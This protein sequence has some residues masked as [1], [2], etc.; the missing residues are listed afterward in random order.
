MT[1]GSYRKI[2]SD[3]WSHLHMLVKD[4]ANYSSNWDNKLRD[5]LEYPSSEWWARA[6]FAVRLDLI[7]WGAEIWL[8]FIDALWVPLWE[9]PWMVGL[10]SF[11]HEY[12]FFVNSPLLRFSISSW[13]RTELC[14][15]VYYIKTMYT[16]LT[17]V[18][19]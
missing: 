8:E 14:D 16:I 11:M 3:R 13:D 2:K 18:L 10:G 5:Y 4:K 7:E 12:S 1:E 19:L 15:T 17:Y 6:Q 9:P